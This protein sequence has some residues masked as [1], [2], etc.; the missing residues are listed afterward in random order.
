MPAV[1]RLTVDTYAVQHPGIPERRS[2]RSV[3]V[4]LI[5]LHL[6]LDRGEPPER[7]TRLLDRLRPGLRDLRWLTPPQ[8]NGTLTIDDVL[9]PDQ[10][11]HD[12]AVTAWA[13]DVWRAWTTHHAV[14]ISW[15]DGAAIRAAPRD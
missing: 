1:H 2:V 5:A 15:F 4:H 8:P 7:V 10:H 11:G 3:A 14:V 9:A 6:T 12:K 13:R